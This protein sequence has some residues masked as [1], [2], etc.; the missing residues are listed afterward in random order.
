MGARGTELQVVCV[1]VAL[2]AVA[3]GGARSDSAGSSLGAAE[4]DSAVDAAE[5]GPTQDASDEPDA[6]EVVDPEAGENEVDATSASASESDAGDTDAG[7]DASDSAASTMDA[8]EDPAIDAGNDAGDS[9]LALCPSSNNQ[10]VAVTIRLTAD[11]AIGALYVDGERISLTDPQSS[12]GTVKLATATLRSDE[13]VAHAIAI[14]ASNLY[15][16]AGDDR[17]LIAELTVE[18]DR[19]APPFV[20]TDRTWKV[21]PAVDSSA[22]I[23]PSFDDSAW[24]SAVEVGTLGVAP[25]GNLTDLT[26]TPAW[27]WSYDP[28]SSPNRPAVEPLTFRKRFYFDANLAIA[29]EPTCSRVMF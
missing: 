3:C 25:W 29:A 18:N 27:I 16:Q 4:N 1:F 19:T 28:S 13:G 26:T 5:P 6:S 20:H 9:A 21:A 8:S 14:E 12:W 2:S 17:G 24:T 7:L 23:S 15:N 22:W 10:T 11:D